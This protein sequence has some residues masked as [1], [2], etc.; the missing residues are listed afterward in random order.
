RRLA[1][2][3]TADDGDVE[4]ALGIPAQRR[5]LLSRAVVLGQVDLN[6]RQVDLRHLAFRLLGGT[7]D[8]L[9]YDGMEFGEAEP[10]FGRERD[11][12]AEAQ[13]EAF[14]DPRLRLAPL[15]LVSDE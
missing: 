3:R 5:A 6:L 14:G 12:L 4:V 15:G 13:L 7:V 2:V 9:R 11:G 8:G 10:V 1:G